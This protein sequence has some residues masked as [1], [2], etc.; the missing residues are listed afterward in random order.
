MDSLD[1]ESTFESRKGD[2]HLTGGIYRNCDNRGTRG[3]SSK[4]VPHSDG[5][6]ISEVK[7]VC[8]SVPG[9]GEGGCR[10][11]FQQVIPELEVEVHPK[12][13]EPNKAKFSHGKDG[14]VMEMMEMK[15]T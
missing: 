11:R 1:S 5:H 13:N 4:S 10:L 8:D 7:S 2:S 9:C 3:L 6:Q 12:A 14:N 15:S